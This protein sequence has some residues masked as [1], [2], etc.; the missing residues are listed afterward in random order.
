[1]R[2]LQTTE[3]TAA[4]YLHSLRETDPLYGAEGL[5]H[6]G[7]LLR[8]CNW[9]LT[10]NVRLGPWIHTGSTVRNLAAAPVGAVLTVAAVV[11]ANHVRKGHGL[12]ELDAVVMADGRPVAQVRHV[13]I[14]RP[15]QLQPDSTG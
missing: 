7:L 4:A 14:W 9:A 3:E 8:T 11:A 12:V 13:A 2:P 15:R 5:L 10:E 1:M 6:P